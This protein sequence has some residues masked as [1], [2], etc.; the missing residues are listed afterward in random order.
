MTQKLVW[1]FWHVVVSILLLAVLIFALFSC[2]VPLKQLSIRRSNGL[3]CCCS[4]PLIGAMAKNLTS[5]A[6]FFPASFFL[7]VLLSFFI[8]R[9]SLL[10]EPSPCDAPTLV[11]RLLFVPRRIPSLL[12]FLWEKSL[13]T[14]QKSHL[15]VKSTSNT[16]MKNTKNET[17]LPALASIC[18]S[19]GT[20][21]CHLIIS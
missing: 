15:P 18:G 8:A 10:L 2:S 12:L 21:F 3:S 7:I 20:R 11:L 9:I 4:F 6:F 19:A 17:Y 5:V 14:Q 13:V 16:T 1:W